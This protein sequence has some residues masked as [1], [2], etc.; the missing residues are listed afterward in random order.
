[1]AGSCVPQG[2][3]VIDGGPAEIGGERQR[4]LLAALTVDAGNVVPVDG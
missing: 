3:G 4:R 2:R 1:M